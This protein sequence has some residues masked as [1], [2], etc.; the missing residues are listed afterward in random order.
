[1]TIVRRG[2]RVR[3]SLALVAIAAAVAATSAFA[4]ATHEEYVAQVNPICK[5]A[6]AVAKRKLDKLKPSGNPFVDFLL[7]SRLYAKLL[8]KTISRIATVPPAPGE[9]AAV[10]SWLDEGRTTVHLINKLLHSFGP[11]PSVHK[12]RVLLKQIHIA[13]GRS[14]KKAKALGLT[15][16]AAQKRP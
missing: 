13:Q 10:A 3:A 16:C 4:T 9:E 12:V 6:S 5:D 15:A 14:V 1:V 11:H 8:D 2:R 7:R